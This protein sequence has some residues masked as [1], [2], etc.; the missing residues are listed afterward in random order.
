MRGF[1]RAGPV[2]GESAFS[3]KD[4]SEAVA[5]LKTSVCNHFQKNSLVSAPPGGRRPPELHSRPLCAPF[6]LCEVLHFSL[7]SAFFTSSEAAAGQPGPLVLV[8]VAL[9]VLW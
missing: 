9:Q 2:G 7:I 3:R 4:L 8:P 1:S 5:S 6:P